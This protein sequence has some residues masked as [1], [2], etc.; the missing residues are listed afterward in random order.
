MSEI[1]TTNPKDQIKVISLPKDKNKDELSKVANKL[2]N[3][4][5]DINAKTDIPKLV[6]HL[7]GIVFKIYEYREKQDKRST[8]ST[9]SD[10]NFKEKKDESFDFHKNLN[11]IIVKNEFSICPEIKLS[12]NHS[13]IPQRIHKTEINKF[14]TYEGEFKNGLK[15]GKGTMNYKNEYAYEGDWKEGKREGKG[16]YI[17]KIT[18]EKL[19]GDFK[20]DKAEGKGIATYKDGSKYEGDYKN[21]QKDGKGIYYYGN[22]DK[23]EG[24]FKQ[25]ISDGKGVYTY[26]NGNI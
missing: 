11:K 1:K 2:E 25:D 3:I 15:D 21:W 18:H 9:Q 13:D 7:K 17:N 10:E 24:E 19:E 16:T 4:I 6:K 23:Y 12:I 5:S 8:I 20:S 14:G 26:K 22:G